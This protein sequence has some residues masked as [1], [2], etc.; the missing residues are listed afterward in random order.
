[1][2]ALALWEWKWRDTEVVHVHYEP[3]P[4]L[5]E[6]MVDLAARMWIQLISAS[7]V[8]HCVSHKGQIHCLF[9]LLTRKRP[10]PLS[11]G[12]VLNISLL[13]SLSLLLFLSSL[14]MTCSF[15]TLNSPIMT[16][17]VEPMTRISFIWWVWTFLFFSTTHFISLLFSHS[18]L[19]L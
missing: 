8:Y 11:F 2:R 1:M 13:L 15:Y 6:C 9:I 10:W 12:E 4:V 19:A 7:L 18:M 3:L 5:D 14:I 16:R 17:V